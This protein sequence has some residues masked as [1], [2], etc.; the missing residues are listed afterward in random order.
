[1][2]TTPTIPTRKVRGDCK[3]ERLAPDQHDRLRVWLERENHT[4]VE[5]VQLIRT[6]FNLSVGK[7][8]VAA[9]WRRHVLP[10]RYHEIAD[11]AVET[12]ALPELPE[13][14]FSEASLKLV[15]MHAYTALASSEPD[16]KTAARL[17][18]TVRSADRLALARERFALEQRRAALREAPAAENRQTE[19]AKQKPA[20]DF[21]SN[22]ANR[23]LPRASDSVLVGGY[24]PDSPNPPLFPGSS[25]DSRAKSGEN[26]PPSSPP[27]HGTQ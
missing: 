25:G 5:I 13:T 27:P 19:E 18:E 1:M 24:Q 3:L 17:L 21:D 22:F 14:R 12:A 11:D 23:P 10:H 7:S 20:F 6:D 16:L 26:F 2:A 4:Y 8:A 9:Y 15:Q